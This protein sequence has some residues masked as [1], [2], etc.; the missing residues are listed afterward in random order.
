[1]ASSALMRVLGR[2]PRSLS[3]ATKQVVSLTAAKAREKSRS[4]AVAGS[5]T[6]TGATVATTAAASAMS[7]MYPDKKAVMGLDLRIA[8]AAAAGAFGAHREMKGKD[9]A[10]TSVIEGVCDGALASLVAEKAFAW[11]ERKRLEGSPSQAA[12]ADAANVQGADRPP[13]RRIVETPEPALSGLR[14]A[15]EFAI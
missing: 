3:A 5:L 12:N 14:R 9:G 10:A 4:E 13:V 2:A 8:V 1:M 7:G 6:R 11:G 15:R